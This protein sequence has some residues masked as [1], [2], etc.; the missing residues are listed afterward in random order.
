MNII[1]CSVVVWKKSEECSFDWFVFAF[2]LFFV[3]IFIESK[4]RRIDL[5]SEIVKDGNVG[6][7]ECVAECVV[8]C[9]VGCVVGWVVG[10]VVV[11]VAGC[12]VGCV[13]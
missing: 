10:C 8:V 4:E 5:T 3:L 1:T 12:V 9:V 6:R 2:V 7:V 11:S 13:V